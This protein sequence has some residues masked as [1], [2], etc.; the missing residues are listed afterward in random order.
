MHRTYM[1]NGFYFRTYKKSLL[2]CFN[3]RLRWETMWG[4]EKPS[5]WSKP[6]QKTPGSSLQQCQCNCKPK[7]WGS[8]HQCLQR[9]ATYGWLLLLINKAWLLII[10]RNIDENRDELWNPED[11]GWHDPR[12]ISSWIKDANLM[13]E[14]W[15][16]KPLEGAP[17]KFLSVQEKNPPVLS[18]FPSKMLQ[19]LTNGFAWKYGTAFTP[20][21][22]TCSNHHFLII[23]WA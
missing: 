22:Q 1:S 20:M 3:P 6:G 13:R 23:W 21:V 7:R 19:S 10:F 11:C 18:G 9:C 15:A 2:F 5:G 16:E 17:W 4:L 14:G 8:V 12:K